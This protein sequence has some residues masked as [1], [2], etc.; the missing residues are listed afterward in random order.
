MKRRGGFTMIELVAVAALIALLT[1]AVLTGLAQWSAK[2]ALARVAQQTYLAAKSARL[3]ALQS[4]KTVALRLDATGQRLTVAFA[5]SSTVSTTATM[6]QRAIRLDEPLV[7]T[8]MAEPA[9]GASDQIR[10]FPNGRS[11]GGLITLADGRRVW[12]IIISA[13]TGRAQLLEGAQTAAVDW[14]DLDRP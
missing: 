2:A 9:S 12:Q 14:M 6:P 5:D 3:K 1:A 8:L 13:A 10:F 11:D 4:G 7:A